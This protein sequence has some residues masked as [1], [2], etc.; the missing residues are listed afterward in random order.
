MKIIEVDSIPKK[1]ANRHNLQDVIKSFIESDA[2]FCRIELADGEYRSW[3]ICYG[4]MYVAVKRSGYKIK[5]KCRDG[6]V[7]LVRE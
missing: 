3:R 2:K 5:V 7:Y 4:C 1:R 6:N